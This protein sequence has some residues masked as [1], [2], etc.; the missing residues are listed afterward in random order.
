MLCLCVWLVE[1]C[2]PT[3][4]AGKGGGGQNFRTSC[5]D[6]DIEID[7]LFRR[8]YV[9]VFLSDNQMLLPLY[10]SFISSFIEMFMNSTAFHGK[11]PRSINKSP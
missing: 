2:W 3:Y 5:K 1:I 11:L 6:F 4:W 7:I 9:V 10:R 8:L